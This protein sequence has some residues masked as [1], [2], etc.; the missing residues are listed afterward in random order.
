MLNERFEL[1][2]ESV[3]SHKMS[4]KLRIF[5]LFISWRIEVSV[6]RKDAQDWY[7]LQ[8]NFILK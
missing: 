3:L 7:D 4:L 5:L 1:H 6:D 2:M 8:F